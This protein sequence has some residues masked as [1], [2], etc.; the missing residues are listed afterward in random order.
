MTITEEN[1][2]DKAE[3]VMKSK[4]VR[5]TSTKMRSIY[6]LCTG[7]YSQ[8][9]RSTEATLSKDLLSQV[10]Y[11]KMRIA[12]ECGRDPNVKNLEKQC[13]LQENISG[14]GTKKANLLLFCR[15]MESLVAYH[16]Y[17]Q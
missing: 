14:I 17:Y 4:N 15:Y 10:Q 5:V 12:Y 11:L 8:A 9:R 3:E 6:S 2:A 13:Q 7:L 1:F 16:K